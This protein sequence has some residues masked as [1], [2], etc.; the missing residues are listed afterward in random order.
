MN[1][2]NL[3][4]PFVAI[5]NYVREFIAMLKRRTSKR[6]VLGDT[7]VDEEQYEDDTVEVLPSSLVEKF[8][9]TL[10][11]EPDKNDKEDE[12]HSPEPDAR[13]LRL[14]AGTLT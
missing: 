3:I 1:I 9:M 6:F 7:S 13:L 2:G 10:A 4:A 5:A 12:D 8:Q 14:P 11:S